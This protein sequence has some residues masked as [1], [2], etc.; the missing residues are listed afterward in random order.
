MGQGC[1]YPMAQ[2][3]QVPCVFL[4]FQ[5]LGTGM[6]VPGWVMRAA[7]PS[8]DSVLGEGTELC[9]SPSLWHVVMVPS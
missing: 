6:L 5:L 7:D 1:V 3:E 2:G 9:S 4:P 8:K